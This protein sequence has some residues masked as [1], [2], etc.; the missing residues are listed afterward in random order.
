MRARSRSLYF[1]AQSTCSS[2]LLHY[3]IEFNLSI[4]IG[5]V[6]S[7]PLPRHATSPLSSHNARLFNERGMHPRPSFSLAL[8]FSLF[9]LCLSLS[10][11]PALLSLYTL[12]LISMTRTPMM[13][14]ARPNAG[15]SSLITVFTRTAKTNVARPYQS[16][17]NR[18]DQ[19]YHRIRWCPVSRVY[20]KGRMFYFRCCEIRS[21]GF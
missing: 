18:N 19:F 9:S 11:S 20:V 21:S 17:Q 8:S 10:F 13:A 2:S 16:P 12:L 3:L 1:R 14:S 15:H 6:F 7:R 5:R 4:R